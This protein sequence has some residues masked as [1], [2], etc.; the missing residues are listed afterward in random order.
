MDFLTFFN[1]KRNC[2]NNKCKYA[3][4]ETTVNEGPYLSFHFED[5]VEGKNCGVLET[6]LTKNYIDFTYNEFCSCNNDLPN[7]N[8]ATNICTIQKKLKVLPKYIIFSMESLYDEQ[9]KL[10]TYLG[11]SKIEKDYEFEFDNKKVRFDLISIIF[12]V[13]NNHFTTAF[14]APIYEGKEYKEWVYYDDL[15]G[16]VVEELNFSTDM[17]KFFSINQIPMLLVYKILHV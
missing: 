15:E 14:K 9:M 5:N 13:N 2:T 6:F 16:N 12:Y 3:H 17:E 1:M 11:K 10:K 8:A 7:Y 4:P